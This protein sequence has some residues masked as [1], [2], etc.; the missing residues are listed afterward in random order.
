[1]GGSRRLLY[2]YSPYYYGD[3]NTVNYV[4]IIAPICS[5]VLL[6]IG[7]YMLLRARYSRKRAAAL[8][9]QEEELQTM[10]SQPE[11]SA[12]AAG[13]YTVPSPA[14]YLVPPPTISH[15]SARPSATARAY[16][17]TPAVDETQQKLY[18]REEMNAMSLPQLKDLKDKLG[19]G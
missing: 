3:T 15:S 10:P 1:M 19:F 8:A 12:T 2:Y 4:R 14:D 11:P 18:S 7:I 5:S 6:L 17:Y 13:S 9:A 16:S